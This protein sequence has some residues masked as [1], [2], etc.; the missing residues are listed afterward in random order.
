MGLHKLTRPLPANPNSKEILRCRVCLAKI[1][2]YADYY[3]FDQLPN[4]R[5]CSL[6]CAQEQEEKI[7]GPHTVF[8]EIQRRMSEKLIGQQMTWKA[9]QTAEAVVRTIVRN[10][11]LEE[12]SGFTEED[13][14]FE[15][16][17]EQNGVGEIKFN[18]ESQQAYDFL[19]SKF[20]GWGR[21]F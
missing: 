8:R 2:Q 11:C 7:N 17:F 18:A 6:D 5:F 20:K 1:E 16:D 15:I 4:D 12:G 14:R 10:I 3:K 13:F 21:N 19:T 9:V